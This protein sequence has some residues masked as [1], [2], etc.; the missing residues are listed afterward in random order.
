[1]SDRVVS[2]GSQGYIMN[3]QE[4]GPEAVLPTNDSA[5]VGR[6]LTREILKLISNSG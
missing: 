6:H 2:V 4:P 5:W 3:S 1:M